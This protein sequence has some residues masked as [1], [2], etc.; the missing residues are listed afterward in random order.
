MQKQKNTTV[1]EEEDRGLIAQLSLFAGARAPLVFRQLPLP[2]RSWRLRLVSV[3]PLLLSL[4]RRPLSLTV[5]DGKDQALARE[6]ISLG[7][8]HAAG[9]NSFNEMLHEP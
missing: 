3:C 8:D 6:R 4:K 7:E 9:S 5:V 2:Y 1:D